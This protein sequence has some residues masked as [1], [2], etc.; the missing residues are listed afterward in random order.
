M[1]SEWE[2]RVVR[3]GPIEPHPNAD[4]LELTKV[5]GGYPCI[6]QKG[7][8]K[9]G[10]LAV[11]I[12]VESVCPDL[13]EYKFLGSKKRIKAIRLRGL[14]S[15]GLIMPAPE[16]T[17]VGQEV[18]KLMDI[19]RYVRPVKNSGSHGGSIQHGG[20]VKGPEIS[21]YGLN[22]FRKYGSAIPTDERLVVTEK[23]HGANFRMVKHKGRL[24]V[25][26]RTR[27][28]ARG[29]SN[30]WDALD[31]VA[32]E[33]WL[34]KCWSKMGIRWFRYSKLKSLMA[35]G[36]VY[37]G[38][39]YGKVQDLKYG[40]EN[41]VSL[42]LFDVKTPL[43]WADWDDVEAWAKELG[44]PLVPVLY[45][46]LWHKDIP[47]LAEGLSAIEGAECIKEGIVIRTAEHDHS[48]QCGRKVLKLHGQGYLT[49]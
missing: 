29:T 12:P 20:S 17:Q 39:V 43:G 1:I 44:L 2:V 23:I 4:R 35:E 22:P 45:Q 25:G 8:W 31:S 26:S 15:M 42:V 21:A 36:A 32:P 13:P 37:Y 34:S 7:Q 19:K 10:D 6:V 30:W 14:F 5:H 18:S 41:S 16:G 49:R 28:K 40:L 3:L 27:W 46:G 24:Y 47:E 33:G 38:E 11:Y 48:P 9:E